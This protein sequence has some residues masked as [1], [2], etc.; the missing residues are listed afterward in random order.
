MKKKGKKQKK[1][2][3][4]KRKKRF[5]LGKCFNCGHNLGMGEDATTR[6]RDATG[7]PA[8]VDCPKCKAVNSYTK[9]YHEW[10]KKVNK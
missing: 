8:Y 10:K 3:K 7:L 5:W 1:N 9:R 4:P 6:G 2:A